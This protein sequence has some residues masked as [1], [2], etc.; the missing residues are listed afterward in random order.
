MAN[1]EKRSE[2][3][4]RITVCNGSDNQGNRERKRKTITL[5]KGLT[6]RQ[7]Q[8]EIDRQVYEFEREVENGTFLDG[9]K[10]TF[11]EFTQTWLTKYAEKELAPMALN[12]YKQLLGRITQGLG[13]LKLNKIQPM[14][15][16][17]FMSDLAGESIRTDNK[18]TLKDE[19]IS[20]IKENKNRLTEVVNPRTIAN[21]LKGKSTNNRIV[22][23]IA[24][25]SNL[26]IS[27]LFTVHNN[28]DKLSQQTLLHHFKLLNTILNTAV[29]WNLL[30]N[31]PASRVQP[32]RVE[33]KE[34]KFLNNDE[35]SKMLELLEN[36][37]S[38]YQ[39]AIYIAI[40]GGLRMGEVIALKWS[41]I[42]FHTGKLSITK[43]GQY[44]SNIGN[45][46][47]STKNESSKRE[48]KLPEIAL[49]KLNE[50]KKEQAI[51]RLL[52]GSQ[53]I[54]N[55][56]IFTQWNGE[57]ISYGT[58]GHWFTEWIATTDLPQ[59]TF[60]GLRHSHASLLIACGKDIATVS[61]RLGHSR[62]STTLDIYTH[63]HSQMDEDAADTL[64]SMFTPKL[65]VSGR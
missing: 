30:L 48:L 52:L 24:D 14:H 49:H 26:D 29:K 39:V 4:Y 65:K 20:Y 12:R 38:K 17:D 23:K 63:S 11:N 59:I 7:K 55:D 10:I 60:H 33:R 18:Y 44:V 45:F 43:A 56:N 6:E 27:V 3:T 42:D 53:W 35:I 40:F 34:I 36:Q 46:E 51:E 16:M 9:S 2:N 13:N 21:I 37:P 58:I 64:D 61:K 47:K 5:P 62:I 28:K 19:Y 22:C 32:P 57:R 25:V 41:D 50:L 1:I 54:N 8:K 31:N 15:I